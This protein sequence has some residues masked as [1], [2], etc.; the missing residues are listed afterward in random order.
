MI[1]RFF[2]PNLTKMSKITL[3]TS[4]SAL[5]DQKRFLDDKMALQPQNQS[6]L[7]KKFTFCFDGRP[8]SYYIAYQPLYFC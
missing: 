8:V 6:N 4:L 1:I 3:K 5:T 2:G 7:A